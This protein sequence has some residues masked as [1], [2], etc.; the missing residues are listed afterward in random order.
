MLM[1][2]NMLMLMLN[3]LLLKKK[4]NRKKIEQRS[5]LENQT[6]MLLCCIYYY[7][8]ININIKHIYVV[9]CLNMRR[10]LNPIY[11][12]LRQFLVRKVNNDD[13][14]LS[15]KRRNFAHRYFG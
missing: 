7:F 5:L 2:Q 3:V 8:F 1:L 4:I 6:N 13:D 10:L 9:A 14:N 15:G 12:I 11:D